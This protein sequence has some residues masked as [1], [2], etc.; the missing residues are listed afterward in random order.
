MNTLD[1]SNEQDLISIRSTLSFGKV[2]YLTLGS[3]SPDE[4]Y[5]VI[6]D[7]SALGPLEQDQNM[8]ASSSSSPLDVHPALIRMSFKDIK[9]E[10]QTPTFV[11]PVGRMCQIF[12]PYGRSDLKT[13]EMVV[14]LLKDNTA[15]MEDFY[16]SAWRSIYGII[17]NTSD[18][19]D[20]APETQ[21][22]IKEIASKLAKGS[23]IADLRMD[24]ELER[25]RCE[26][27]RAVLQEPR[28]FRDTNYV[29]V[30]DAV[31]P[32]HSVWLIRS[33]LD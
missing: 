9:P 15:P 6:S 7:P 11:I 30:V 2:N 28:S 31:D 16:L 10:R 17:S 13:M 8:F 22:Y 12:M 23:Q 25:H 14:G 21:A 19:P 20:H 18:L 29:V 24:Q 26:A 5:I 33:V 1:Y 32:N 3:G 27:W 4:L